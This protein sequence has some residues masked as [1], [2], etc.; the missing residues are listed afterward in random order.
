MNPAKNQQFHVKSKITGKMHDLAHEF[1]SRKISPWGGIKYFQ[2]TYEKTG[3]K[4]YLNLQ[5]LPTP[6]SNRGYQ[7]TDII[8][9]FMT[10][11]VLGAKRLD[12]SGMLRSDEVVR[13][14]FGWKK[15]M[16]SASTFSRFFSKFDIEM[17]DEVFP[18]IMKYFFDQMSVEKMTVDID[19]TVITRYGE[20]ECAIKGYNPQKR[21]RASHHPIMAFCDELKMVVNAWMR[22]GNSHSLTQCDEFLEETI[23]II[24]E[25]RI[26]LLRGDVGFYSDKIMRLLEDREQPI[27]YIFRAKMTGPIRN[28]LVKRSRWYSN[29]DVIKGSCYREI[30]YKASK[31]EKPRRIILVRIPDNYKKSIQGELFEEYA[32]LSKYRY[33][34]YV[35]NSALPAVTI[36]LLYTKRGDAENRIKEL[37][38]DYGIDG[39]ALHSFA[40][41]EAAFRFTMV[42]FNI[43]ALFKQAIMT[44]PKHH[45]LSTVRF[46]CIAIGSYLVKSGR[47]KIMKLAAEGKRRHFLQHFFDNLEHLKPPYSLSNA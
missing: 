17:N 25:G 31:W 11:V 47:K 12:H 35:T 19:S 15:G 39:F 46:Q 42:A 2:Q 28:A 38:Y 5:P 21:N 18:A 20:Q 8:E 14:I 22:S 45:R 1:T 37:K 32:D 4:G 29:D 30:K 10:S 9:G 3:L 27:P 41:M 36:H 6:G 23:G 16:A 34:A 26:G 44:S 13:E 24:G 33:C 43:M 7:A 40:G